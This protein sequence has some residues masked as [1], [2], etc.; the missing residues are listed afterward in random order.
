MLESIASHATAPRN[1]APARPANTHCQRCGVVKWSGSR[2]N[3]RG[4]RIGLRIAPKPPTMFIKPETLPDHFTTPQ[5]WQ[6]VLAGLAGAWLL[7]AVAWLLIDSS[8][9]LEPREADL[10]K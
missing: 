1:Q 6:W 8:K 7:A 10:A 4:M 2:F 9:T 5:R 3:T